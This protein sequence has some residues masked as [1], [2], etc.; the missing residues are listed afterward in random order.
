M[1]LIG[2]PCA[3]YQRPHPYP[4]VHGNHITYIRALE[5]VGGAP[6]LIPLLED[7]RL[8]RKIWDQLDGLLLAGGSDVDPA[9]YGQAPHAQLG[10]VD[11]QQDR[12]ELQ[13]CRWAL[14]EGKPIL[15]ICRGIQVLNVAAGGTLYQHLP[16]QY[17]SAVNHEESREQQQRALHTHSL[18][19]LPDSRLAQLLDATQLMVNS[20]HHQAICDLAAPL[21]AVGWS[22]D[23]LI[24]AVESATNQWVIGVQCHPEEL[25]PQWEAVFAQ[26]VRA[27]AEWRTLYV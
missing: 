18:E 2:I 4:L 14:A 25:M 21:Q 9:W 26:F 27:A 7:E 15:A 20:L 11:Q 10:E 23:R 17:S 12:V 8:L 19:L 16:D 5:N 13:L 1:P 6:L 3:V 22:D 24:E